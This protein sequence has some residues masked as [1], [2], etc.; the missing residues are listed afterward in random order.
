MTTT[1]DLGDTGGTDAVIYVGEVVAGDRGALEVAD[2]VALAVDEW[3]QACAKS[4]HTEKAYRLDFAQWREHAEQRGIDVLA[5]TKSDV[6]GWRHLLETTVSPRTGRLLAVATLARKVSTLASFYRWLEDSDRIE[7]TPVRQLGRPKAPATS[8]TV[9]MSRHEANLFLHRLQL[10]S[11]ADRAILTTMLFTGARVSELCALNVGDRRFN[12]DELTVVIEGKGRRP[13]EVPLEDAAIAAIAEHLT[14]RYGAA[15]PPPDAPLFVDY[16][17]CRYTQKRLFRRVRRVARAAGI[18]SF[19]HLS[20]H[21]IRHTAITLM[22][23][24]G[25]QLNV[26]QEIAGHAHPATTI[27][28]DRA[29]GRITH[30]AEAVRGLA[31]HILSAPPPQR[32]SD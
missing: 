20:N 24:D 15:E 5:P 12:A 21:G 4:A 9:A 25:R 7:K 27:R 32:R 19:A 6:D 10:E 29:R 2:P 11:N 8:T 31:D 17:G 26:V 1:A 14:D 22:L 28:Y 3:I 13:R 30:A 16:D 23:D 18:T